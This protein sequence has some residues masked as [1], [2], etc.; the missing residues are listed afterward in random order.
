[1]ENDVSTGQVDSI[2]LSSTELNQLRSIMATAIR[3][4]DQIMGL[5]SNKGKT[6]AD[7]ILN[8]LCE[9]YNTDRVQIKQYRRNPKLVERKRMACVILKKYTDRTNAEIADMVGY[10]NHATV[11]YHV[12]EAESLL[13]DEVYGDKEF[14]RTYSKLIKHLNL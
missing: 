1:M 13:S 5:K 7:H 4:I 12:K 10:D 9:F 2:L 3:R 6:L 8:G 14:K 11:L